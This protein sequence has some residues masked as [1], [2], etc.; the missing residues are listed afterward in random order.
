MRHRI[1]LGL[2]WITL[3]LLVA[4]SGADA[5]TEKFTDLPADKIAIKILDS[6]TNVWIPV[7]AVVAVIGLAVNMFAGFVQIGAK[8]AGVVIG[9]SL[10]AVG[11]PGLKAI[12]GGQFVTT[13]ILP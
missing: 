10:L 9:L 12:F 11:L 7:L 13:L 8:A 4:A 2:L 1:V 6:V 5:T 3:L